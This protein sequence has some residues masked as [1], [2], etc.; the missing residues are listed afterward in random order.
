[1]I[2]A[3]KSDREREVMI[4]RSRFAG[5][6][7]VLFFLI[8]LGLLS[9]SCYMMAQ[10]PGAPSQN[11]QNSQ[12]KDTT[13][14][15]TA[16]SNQKQQDKSNSELAT[17]DTPA[18]FKVRVNLVQV[19]AVVRDA[20]GKPVENLQKEDFQLYDGRKLQNISTF[21][22][23][24]AAS[25][26][27]K[28]ATMP[29]SEPT[30]A[31]NGETPAGEVGLAQR[32]VAM[33]FD[34]Q[35]LAVEDTVTVREAATHFLNA[36]APGDRAGIYSTSGQ[37][38]QGFTNDKDALKRK[39][40]GVIPRPTTQS[41]GSD[42][43]AI[44]YYQG[45]L[46]VNQNDEQALAVAAEDTVQCAFNGDETKL[47]QARVVARNAA[48][49][50]VVN[51]DSQS[52]YAY[53]HLNEIVGRLAGMP[54]ERV[55]VLISPGFLM[56]TLRAEESALVDRANH[57][58][59]VINTLDGRGLYTPDVLGDIANPP[60]AGS[61]RTAGYRVSYRVQAQS[62]QTEVLRDFAE[63]TG[64]TFFHNRNDLES[65]LKQEGLM[66]AVSYLLGFSPQNLKLDGSYHTLRVAL[67]KKQKF[68]VQA[69]HGYYAPRQI[70]NPDLQAKEEIQ[71]AVFSQEEIRDIPLELQ[72]QFFKPDAGQAKLAVLLR[73]DLKSLRFR[74]ADGRNVDNLTVATAIFDENGNFISGGE[75]IVEMKL[76]EPTYERLNKSGL[77][78]KSSFDVKPGKYLVRLVIRDSEGSQ[79][80]ARNGAVV[81]PY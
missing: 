8:P 55:M 18:A 71:E 77:A 49:R 43:P 40:L 60:A 16:V 68:T 58:N 5:R 80:A 20:D 32:F 14:P 54:G 41:L 24:T 73:V 53:S 12:K 4:E 75:K 23:E 11:T 74:K 42:C 30:A 28:V 10:E 78:L 52:Q 21:E 66:P 9:H 34:D 47:A 25:R 81:I 70:T 79:M 33:V 64:G 38:T 6:F 2:P 59:I 29:T 61:Y 36:L 46:I 13:A 39:L 48:T 1:M 45:N 19:R 51:G 65:G 26:R 7:G 35:N 37:V 3:G 69:R 44:S 63:G 17:R 22:V 76:L 27:L 72:T 50:A 62:A 67:A 57:S 31:N 56:S 15:A